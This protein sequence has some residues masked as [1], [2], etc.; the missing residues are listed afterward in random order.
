MINLD[1]KKPGSHGGSLRP[2]DRVRNSGHSDGGDS[3]PVHFQGMTGTLSKPKVKHQSFLAGVQDPSF[4][5]IEDRPSMGEGGLSLPTSIHQSYQQLP[6]HQSFLLQQ[7]QQNINNHMNTMESS[8]QH[9][10]K[11]SEQYSR[12]NSHRNKLQ[13]SSNK[14][15]NKLNSSKNSI[16]RA[17]GHGASKGL[18][19]QL[20]NN[21]QDMSYS[22]T[23]SKKVRQSY[24]IEFSKKKHEQ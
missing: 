1:V 17:Q 14:P 16:R 6:E 5:V 3:T 11:Q 8:Q 4:I 9:K 10:R 21:S 2:N 18:G 20:T 15:R 19:Q 22:S 12:V 13:I 23:V 24:K 7:S